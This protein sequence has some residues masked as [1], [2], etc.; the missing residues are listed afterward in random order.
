MGKSGSTS[1][2]LLLPPIMPKSKSAHRSKKQMKVKQADKDGIPALEVFMT[3]KQIQEATRKSTISS[4]RSITR[5]CSVRLPWR[6]F[7]PRRFYCIQSW[8]FV[9]SL[10][11]PFSYPVLIHIQGHGSGTRGRFVLACQNNGATVQWSIQWHDGNRFFQ[12]Y[13]LISILF[14]YNQQVFA[15]VCWY[16]S[17]D[18]ISN[19]CAKKPAQKRNWYALHHHPCIT[20]I[21]MIHKACRLLSHKWTHAVGPPPNYWNH[22]HWRLLIVQVVPWWLTDSC[23]V[24]AHSQL[25]L[26]DDSTVDSPFISRTDQ[27]SRWAFKYKA[28]DPP[29]VGTWFKYYLKVAHSNTT[30]SHRVSK[31]TALAR[32]VDLVVNT[33]QTAIAKGIALVVVAGSTLVAFSRWSTSQCWIGY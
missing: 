6:W 19:L 21:D 32:D 8:R 22:Q 11:C 28:S 30:I 14:T 17:I 33:T 10:F 16:Y 13:L 25:I 1:S 9:H 29:Q 23:P 15:F 20:F 7:W 5:C 2:V 26:Y 18:D 24:V 27:F 12:L 3:Y 4:S 31:I